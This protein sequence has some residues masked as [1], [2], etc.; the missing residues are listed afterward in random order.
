MNAHESPAA[1]IKEYV[2]EAKE[3]IPALAGAAFSP[4]IRLNKLD[5]L[6]CFCGI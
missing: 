5:C 1:A 6:V 2:E 4:M 3:L